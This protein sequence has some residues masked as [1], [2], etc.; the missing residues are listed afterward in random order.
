[1]NSKEN[2]IC[3]VCLST[4]D[5][6][7][8][9]KTS[10]SNSKDHFPD[11][12][13]KFLKFVQNYLSIS[14]KATNQ[15]LLLS[16]ASACESETDAF[17]PKCQHEVIH[18]ICQVYLELLSAQLRLSCHLTQLGKLLT[19]RSS[20]SEN[21]VSQRIDSEENTQLLAKRLG[22]NNVT[23]LIELREVLKE[24]CEQNRK[25][26]SPLIV[27][28]SSSN[29][30][31]SNLFQ[32]S[33]KKIVTVTGRAGFE[34]PSKSVVKQESL[35]DDNND[36]KLEDKG[37]SYSFAQE[38]ND[39]DGSDFEW[40]PPASP[41]N[42][43][44]TL[45]D[46]LMEDTD[47]D[48]EKVSLKIKR[49]IKREVKT[50]RKVKPKKV[51]VEADVEVVEGT[52]KAEVTHDF[53]C[54]FCWKSFVDESSLKSHVHSSHAKRKGA[55]YG[56]FHCEVENC[57]GP[58]NFDSSADLNTHLETHSPESILLC[59]VCG[60]GFIEKK[61]LKLHELVH[62]KPLK[63]GGINEKR[64][65]CPE[66]DC[67]QGFRS[68]SKLQTHFN[69]RHGLDLKRFKCLEEGC[70]HLATSSLALLQHNKSAHDPEG[71]RKKQE[72]GTFP[73]P[74]C[75]KIFSTRRK[76]RAHELFV[77]GEKRHKCSAC[78]K[79][80]SCRDSLKKHFIS[81]HDPNPTICP[82]CGKSFPNYIYLNAHIAR[83][84][85]E[86]GAEPPSVQ[87]PHCP[88]K[89]RLKYLLRRH[90]LKEHPDAPE[91]LKCSFCD[92]RMEARMKTSM[93]EHEL[94]HISREERREWGITHICH[95]CGKEF[96]CKDTC[97]RHIKK[98]HGQGQV[99]KQE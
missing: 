33:E 1:M 51:K 44:E 17:C 11:L 15:L 21:P 75:P 48:L 37:E 80:F 26:F 87:C 83:A 52:E 57:P 61:L 25:K 72:K 32:T 30:V 86:T 96:L 65:K 71:I 8:N 9:N 5:H 68:I 35:N 28:S 31:E 41:P 22:V 91:N 50:E 24:K 2:P 60:L 34:L 81:R 6:Y 74:K 77:H 14:T 40:C 19:L 42:S 69:V 4:F 62:I 54:C 73:C 89:F 53:Q 7:S 90:I 67:D 92:L 76:Q 59:S 10:D 49:K 82:H 45:N 12:F 58:S 29:G 38:A 46:E 18:P 13:T 88:E 16:S 56:K 84:H 66:E 23:D 95:V 99:V 55:N 98:I 79:V 63:T 64:L 20:K 36:D 27:A 43:P 47:K 70:F 94:T 85:P 93:E 78:D 3:L 97:N 39:G